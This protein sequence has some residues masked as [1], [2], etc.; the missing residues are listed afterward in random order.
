[1]KRILLF[2][3]VLTSSLIGL[4]GFTPVQNDDSL[5]T[6]TLSREISLDDATLGYL[7]EHDKRSDK[8]ATMEPPWRNNQRRISSIPTGSYVAKRAR[9]MDFETFEIT[10]VPGRSKVYFH[11]GNYPRDTKGC[12]LVGKRFAQT[13]EGDT[14]I[15]LS[16]QAFAEFMISMQ[17]IDQFMINIEDIE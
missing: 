5:H 13:P 4:S 11:P 8:W 3:I 10:G 9:F 2:A 15:L 16:K 6:I 1:M 7:F 14:M 17:G 12:V